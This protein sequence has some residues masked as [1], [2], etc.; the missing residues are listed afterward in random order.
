MVSDSQAHVSEDEERQ[1]APHPISG[2]HTLLATGLL[3]PPI[4]WSV[5]LA[6]S[7]GLVYPAERLHDKTWLLAS[8]LIGGLP[9]LASIVIG[10][11][12]LQ[13]AKPAAEPSPTQGSLRFLAVCACVQGIFFV[14]ATFALVLPVLLLD[15][16][17]R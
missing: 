11:R 15:L 6:L 4:A 8:A 2:E 16:G 10:L 5:Q 17:S 9:A 13:R 1:T 7:Y 3:G 14:L 12:G